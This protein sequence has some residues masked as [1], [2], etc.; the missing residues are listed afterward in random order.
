VLLLATEGFGGLSPNRR[1]IFNDRM[2]F[3][4][5]ERPFHGFW[6]YIQDGRSRVRLSAYP[7]HNT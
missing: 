3:G 4:G 5:Y 2:V 7:R 6:I 1:S